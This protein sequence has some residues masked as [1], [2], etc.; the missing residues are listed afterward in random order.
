MRV[1]IRRDDWYSFGQTVGLRCPLC[2][3]PVAVRPAAV[4][5]DGALTP[6]PS[7]ETQG[8]GFAQDVTLEGWSVAQSAESSYLARSAEAAS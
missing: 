8:C 3:Q 5:V 7:C 6:R 1:L 4:T 2:R